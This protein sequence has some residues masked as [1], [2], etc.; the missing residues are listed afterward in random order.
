MRDKCRHTAGTEDKNTHRGLMK[1][2]FAHSF[3][4][5]QHETRIPDNQMTSDSQLASCFDNIME[6]S[7]LL[8]LM[9]LDLSQDKLYKD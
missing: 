1:L 6:H 3:S 4:P 9:T 8:F 2:P 7:F 5:G